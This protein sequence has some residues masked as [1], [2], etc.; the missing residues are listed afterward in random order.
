MS[1]NSQLSKK[2]LTCKLTVLWALSSVIRASSIQHL[3]INFMAKTKSCYKFY[4]ISFIRVGEKVKH[5][6]Q[7]LIRNIPKVKVF[8]LPGLWMNILHEQRCGDLV[9]STLNFY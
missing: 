8:V 4:L 7:P 9:K 2:N 1:V 6:Q 3:N 5:H